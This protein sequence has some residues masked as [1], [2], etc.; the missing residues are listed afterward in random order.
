MGLQRPRLTR[1]APRANAL[2]H[3]SMNIRGHR[4][5]DHTADVAIEVWAASEEALLVE[6]ARALI[7]VLTEDA[8]IE[9]SDQC[10]LD[11]ESTDGE[12]RLV[13][14]LNEVLW[15]AIGKGF[16]LS[17]ADISLHADGLSARI[18]GQKDGSDRIATEIKSATYHDLRLAREPSGRYVAR[19]VLDV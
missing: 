7:A 11:L 16:L 9:Q 6:A 17:D 19:V 10:A 1:S 2:F 12:D 8:C 13:R 15:L 5:V 14:W 3:E 4:F 18:V